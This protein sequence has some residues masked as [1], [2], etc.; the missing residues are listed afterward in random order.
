MKKHRIQKRIILVYY[1]SP[2]NDLYKQ[3]AAYIILYYK[4]G[5]CMYVCWYVHHGYAD[6]FAIMDQLHIL[7]QES[8][9]WQGGQLAFK[10]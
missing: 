8:L 7:H 5:R 1:L 4:N 3:H 6:D 2:R 10:F 9:K